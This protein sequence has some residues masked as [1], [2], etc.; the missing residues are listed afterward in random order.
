MF[1]FCVEYF[2]Q[3]M[4]SVKRAKQDE[5]RLR[6]TL[7]VAYFFADFSSRSPEK[8]LAKIATP[9]FDVPSGIWLLS[10]TSIFAFIRCP[11]KSH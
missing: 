6:K 2:R 1:D 10:R 5:F 11:W 9:R 8:S 7:A 4:L 3:G